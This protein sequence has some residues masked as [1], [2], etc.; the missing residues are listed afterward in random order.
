MSGMGKCHPWM[1]DIDVM[2][3]EDEI[4]KFETV[5][6]E[7]LKGCGF[8][9]F[10]PRL[11][12]NGGYHILALQKSRNRDDSI[13]FIPTVQVKVPW[14]QVDVFYSKVDEDGFIRNCDG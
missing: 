14:A 6:L 9:F 1:D 12:P 7:A 8:H 3:F 2:I 4:E 13:A 11:W 10:A 5:V